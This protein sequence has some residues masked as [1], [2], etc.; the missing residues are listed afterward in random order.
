MNANPWLTYLL[1]R[2]LKSPRLSQD[3]EL[4]VAQTYEGVVIITCRFLC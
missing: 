1:I 2:R 4:G 3:R